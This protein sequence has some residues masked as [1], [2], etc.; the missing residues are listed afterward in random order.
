MLE[1]ILVYHQHSST[2]L[3]VV[4]RN[5]IQHQVD[6]V[7]ELLNWWWSR[8][9]QENSLLVQCKQGGSGGGR[10]TYSPSH[11]QYTGTTVASPDGRSPTVQGYPGANSGPTA[12]GGG[13][14][15]GEAAPDGTGVGGDGLQ[16]F[17]A[18]PPGIP[19]PSHTYGADGGYFAGGGGGEYTPGTGTPGYAGGKGGGGSAA[20]RTADGVRGKQNTG[21]GGAV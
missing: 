6:L 3:R 16:I 18:D 1:R 13:G 4:I 15:A 19:A 20:A 17:I 9:K 7:V 2:H 8:S 11:P 10:D 14:G 5:F 12:G 21:G